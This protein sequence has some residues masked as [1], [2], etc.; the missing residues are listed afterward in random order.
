[1]LELDGGYICKR[2]DRLPGLHDELPAL[3]ENLND[4]SHANRYQKSHDQS[5]N[6][7]TKK[8]LDVQEPSISGLGDRLGQPL[9]GI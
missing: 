1:M 7:P 3:L 2:F 8:R 5:R 9:D 4:R 6:G